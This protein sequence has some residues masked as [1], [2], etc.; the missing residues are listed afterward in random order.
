MESAAESTPLTSQIST[1]YTKSLHSNEKSLSGI[2]EH[3]IN[4]S[5]IS[6][7]MGSQN[8]I[9]EEKRKNPKHRKYPYTALIYPAVRMFHF[10]LCP[11]ETKAILLLG[12]ERWSPTQTRI[13]LQYKPEHPSGSSAQGEGKQTGTWLCKA[14][15]GTFLW[16]LPGPSPCDKVC[17]EISANYCVI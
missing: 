13:I 12:Q 16:V 5:S 3:S 10:L 17:L 4:L 2:V 14:A 15:P 6:R 9:L 1:L 8:N 11:R 7:R